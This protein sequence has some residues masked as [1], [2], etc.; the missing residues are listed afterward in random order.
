M[1]LITEANSPNFN[2][3]EDVLITE[4]KATGKREAN[5]VGPFIQTEVKNRNG[6]VYGKEMMARAVDSYI[7]DRMQG[8]KYRSYGELGHPEGVEINLHRVSHIITEMDWR[9]SD[10]IGKAKILTETEYGRLAD[11]FLRNN[12]Q[13]GVS[14]RGLGNLQED[15]MGG[16]GPKIVEDFELVAVDIVADPSAP[17]GFVEGILEGKEYI[18]NGGSFTESSLRR[19]VRAYENFERKLK[20]MPKKDVNDYFVEQIKNFLKTL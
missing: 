19:S 1:K 16:D 4:D 20:E 5:I 2:A 15:A 10:V 7:K 13:L 12:C 14:S 6:R 3:I 18:I 11:T 9:G 17:E 8:S